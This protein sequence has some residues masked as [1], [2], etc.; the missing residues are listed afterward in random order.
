MN[1]YIAECIG[2]FFLVFV[3]TLTITQAQGNVMI[4]AL[5]F[6]ITLALIVYFLGSISGA[7]V[8]PA[9]S[10][11]LWC[12]GS[13]SLH[14]L[15]P[16][17]VAQ[18]LGAVFG[19]LFVSFIVAPGALGETTFLS[20]TAHSAFMIEAV[21]TFLFVCVIVK[22]GKAKPITA[23]ITVGGALVLVHL[24]GLPLTGAGVNPARSIAPVVVGANVVAARQIWV[25]IAGPLLGGA[26]AGIA[27]RYCHFR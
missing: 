18:F 24:V 22:M 15:V 27:S 2:T 21:L 11:G 19:S 16:Y 8:N 23:A 26:L 13:F 10:L 25:Y 20:V 9:V 17:W 7:H 5:G 3:G 6:G 12:A 1:K 4:I 14:D